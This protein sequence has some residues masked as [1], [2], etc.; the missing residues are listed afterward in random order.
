MSS[1]RDQISQLASYDSGI[2]TKPNKRDSYLFEPSQAAEHD[3]NS[4]H[5]LGISGLDQLKDID[6]SFG[7]FEDKLFSE[8]VKNLDRTS[9][10]QSQVND[11]NTLLNRFL[12]K[13]SPYLMTRYSAKVLEWLIRKFRV[14]EF[15]IEATFLAFLPYHDSTAFAKIVQLLKISEK[16][17][18]N[19][20]SFLL[21]IKKS[22]QSLQRAVLVRSMKSDH[23]LLKLVGESLPSAL[24]VINEHRPMASFWSATLIDYIKQQ[25]K[26]INEGELAT[27]FSCIR[28]TLKVK[29][30]RDVQY[31][32][33]MVLLVLSQSITLGDKV[34][35]SLITSMFR[36]LEGKGNLTDAES[37]H[38]LLTMLAVIE[39][40][41]I[42]VAS[43]DVIKRLS[44]IP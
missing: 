28:A 26:K 40:Q 38:I 33:R 12:I 41:G 32:G 4:I 5:L 11:L 16:T 17:S 8:N 7:H 3:I 22:K 42:Q 31:A 1:L 10:N 15:N 19:K 23:E 34:V 14:N 18:S 44:V 36:S 27:L 39:N 9:L 20:F 24:E 13:L 35:T 43:D 30:S 6:E 2:L 21:S 37:D 25:S 29:T